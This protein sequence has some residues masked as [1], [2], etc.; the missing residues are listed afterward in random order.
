MEATVA[1]AQ[2]IAQNAPLVVGMAKLIIDQGDGLDKHTQMAIE[3]WAQSQLITS[4]DV[5]E[6]VAAYMEKRPP[7]FK[8]K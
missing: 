5:T 3:R 4:E 2:E 6:A 7:R 1:L 8:G